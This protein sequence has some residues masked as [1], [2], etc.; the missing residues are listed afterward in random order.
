MNAKFEGVLEAREAPVN[1]KK[2]RRD[3]IVDVHLLPNLP[4]F[5]LFL[6]SLFIYIFFYFIKKATYKLGNSTT[7]RNKAEL[8]V[9][10]Y[11]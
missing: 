4:C 3:G 6:I 2:K 1:F 11:R 10:V 5:S 8:K 9:S 7:K